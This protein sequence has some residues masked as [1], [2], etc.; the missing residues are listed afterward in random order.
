MMRCGE[1]GLFSIHC[2]PGYTEQHGGLFAS[3]NIL[4]AVRRRVDLVLSERLLRLSSAQTT[5]VGGHYF[6]GLAPANVQRSL[7]F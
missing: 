7:A 5:A 1:P 3:A 4:L 6:F 2:A